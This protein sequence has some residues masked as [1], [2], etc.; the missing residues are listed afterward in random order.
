V[1]KNM[2]LRKILESSSQFHHE[3][4]WDLSSPPIII[5]LIKQR[6]MRC[7]G[8]VHIMGRCEI[9]TGFSWREMKERSHLKDPRYRWWGGTTHTH[10]D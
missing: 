8:D 9:H 3:E 5:P 7:M 1:F 10:K 2:V 6:Q 4:L